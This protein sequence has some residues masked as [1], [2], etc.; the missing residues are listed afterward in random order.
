MNL[1]TMIAKWF[2]ATIAFFGMGDKSNVRWVIHYNLPKKYRRVL[3]GNW[4]LVAMVCHQKPY[5]SKVMA[6]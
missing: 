1:S 6:M 2:C 5:Y 4:S 3:S